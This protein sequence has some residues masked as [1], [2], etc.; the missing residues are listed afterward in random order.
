MRRTVMLAPAAVLGILMSLSACGS[1]TGGPGQAQNQ[2][3]T[4][5]PSP[6]A[7]GTDG[8]H[9]GTTT[10]PPNTN[11]TT[12][13]PDWPT[14]EDC[15]VYNPNTLTTNYEAGI[16]VVTDGSHVVLRL[17]GGPTDSVGQQGIAVAQR[18]AKRCYIGR[19]NNRVEAASYVFDYWRNPT[20][21]STVIPDD[22]DLC[23]SYNRHNLTVE[24]MGNGDGWRV[25][26]HDHVL[27]LFDN[28]TDARNGKLVLSKYDQIC[29]IGHP[30]DD[31]Q[32]QVSFFE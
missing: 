4:T 12:A 19:T 1:G 2:T 14:P 16:W 15:V 6:T 30:N 11:S 31:T 22:E 23:S 28:E 21:R 29:F 13:A 24:D 17:Q 7:A 20:G 8:P 18:Y 26:D 27:Q 3:P 32:D 10:P 25:K 9:I 5:T